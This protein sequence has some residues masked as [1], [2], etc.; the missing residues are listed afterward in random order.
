MFEQWRAY[1]QSIRD[2]FEDDDEDEYMM[3]HIDSLDD[4]PV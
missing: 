2:N 1:N 3:N 4:E